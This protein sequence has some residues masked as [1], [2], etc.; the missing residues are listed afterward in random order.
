MVIPFRS[1]PFRMRTERKSDSVLTKTER[2][3]GKERKKRNGK[4][5]KN[6]TEQFSHAKTKKR[7]ET[8]FFSIAVPFRF[9]RFSVLH[10]KTVPFRFFRSVIFRFFRSVPFFRFAPFPFRSHAERVEHS[11]PFSYGTER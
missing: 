5:E 2:K 4:T 10:A 3:N 1:V 9:F 8:I 7:S 6:G 11:V